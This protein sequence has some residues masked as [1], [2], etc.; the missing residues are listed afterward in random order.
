M[1][2][3][4]RK[5]WAKPVAKTVIGASVLAAIVGAWYLHDIGE[6]Y[7]PEIT[8][9]L[10]LLLTIIP[11]NVAVLRAKPAKTELPPRKPGTLKHPHPN[12]P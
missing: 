2:P 8:A 10:L 3:S 4:E 1:L 7:I 6:L 9:I 5:P 11:P 12:T